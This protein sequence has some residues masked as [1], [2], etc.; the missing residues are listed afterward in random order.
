MIVSATIHLVLAAALFA[1]P[2]LFGRGPKIP[3]D[4]VIVELAPAY[5]A[6]EARP[7]AKQPPAPPVRAPQPAPDPAEGVRVETKKP[8]DKP[9]ELED[10]PEPPPKEEQPAEQPPEPVAAAPAPGEAGPGPEVEEMG[11]P[12]AGHGVAPLAGGDLQFAWYR[13]SVTAALYSNWQR[14]ILSGLREEVQVTVAFDIQRDGSVTRLRVE[15][16][17]GVP[18]LDRSALRSVADA[19]PLPAL[20]SNW[21]E[22]TLEALF[23]F[24]LYPEGV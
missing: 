4:A 5:P 16:G 19:S 1:G 15:A 2:R 18:S 11:G 14:P 10:T 22:S 8:P 3:Y 9:K 7:A 6:D 12:E 20:P 24:R 13:A 23:V 21:R 17:S